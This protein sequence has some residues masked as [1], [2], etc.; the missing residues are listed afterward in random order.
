MKFED[1]KKQLL[2]LKKL[3]REEHDVL[4]EAVYKDLRRVRC[5]L[6]LLS[7]QLKGSAGGG[8]TTRDATERRID[9]NS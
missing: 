6:F 7:E 3:L 5:F 8:E 4:T 9:C 1:R 2:A